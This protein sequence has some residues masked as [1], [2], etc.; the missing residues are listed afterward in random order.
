VME[1]NPFERQFQ[2]DPYPTYRW[3]RDFAPCYR[4]EELDFYALSRYKDVMEAS[5]QPLLFSS[6][7]GTT[8]E[9]IDTQALL[10]MM[11]FMDPPHHDVYRKLVG[12]AFTP[13]AVSDLE[14]FIRDCAVEFLDQLREKGN[15]DVVDD[16]SAL[17][18]LNVIMELIGVPGADRFMVR[19]WIDHSLDRTEEPPFIPDH[20]IEA[21][22]KVSDYWK[23]LVEEKRLHPDDKL[24]SR[25]CEV[26]L[27][28]EDGERHKLSDED[29]IG[30]CSLIGF[31]GTETLTKLLAS[32]IVLFHRN[33]AQWRR[34]LG[35]RDLIPG[36]VEETLR[37]WAPSQYQG[38]VLT[39][40]FE[41]C[42]T[43]LPKG[44]R[45][46]LLT[47][48]ANRDEREYPE[49]DTF[50]IGRPQHL[51]LGFGHGLHFCLG[52]ALARVE[53]RVGLEEFAIRFPRYEVDETNLRRVHHSNVHG[54]ASVPFR[55]A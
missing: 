17:L 46:L 35:D 32:A 45:V 10:P 4:N 3:L 38:R 16:F 49:P 12:R 8:L 54:F 47:G 18:P 43:T 26:E 36:A 29:I 23:A 52:A 15:G 24:L 33:P 34:L 2:A 11:I 22:A 27:D 20:A 5:Q 19:E 51:A 44:A 37:Y 42:G 41:I 39:E 55:A 13:R 25:L 30:F 31:A 50:D 48:S 6:A 21:M 1:L 7:E 28:A 53:A 40:E 9:R 14:P